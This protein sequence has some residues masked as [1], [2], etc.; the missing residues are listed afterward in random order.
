[1]WGDVGGSGEACGVIRKMMPRV[2]RDHLTGFSK[3]YDTVFNIILRDFC[4]H[5]VPYSDDNVCYRR[6]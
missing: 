1:M 5:M 6:S 4:Y 3:P 2:M